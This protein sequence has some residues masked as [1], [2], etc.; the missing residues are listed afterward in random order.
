MLLHR[1]PLILR[2]AVRFL[3]AAFFWAAVAASR[4][5]ARE[6]RAPVWQKRWVRVPLNMLVDRNAAMARDIVERAAKAGYNGVVYADTKL[7]TW[8]GP[9]VGIGEKWKRNALAFRRLA[10]ER[11]MDFIVTAAPFGYAGGI[12]MHDPNLAAGY[13]VRNVSLRAAE[14][15]LVSICDVRIANPSF[16]EHRGDRFPSWFHDDPGRGSFAD[17]Q[18]VKD[19]SVSLRFEVGARTNKWGHNR[20][21]QTWVVRPFQQ[22]RVHYWI[23]LDKVTGNYQSLVLAADGKRTLQTCGFREKP[24]EDAP[25]RKKLRDTSADWCEQVVVFNSLNRRK[26]RFYIGIWGG[27]SG[28]MWVDGVRIE[29]V[30]TLNVLRRDD[31]PL[32]IAGKDGTVYIE[33]RDYRRVEDPKLGRARW[34]GTYGVIHASPGVLLAPDSRIREGQTVLFSAYHALPMPN[35]QMNCSLYN[36][37]VFEICR[38]S[39]KYN[40]E[41]FHPDGW[42]LAYDEMRTGGWE[43]EETKRFRNSGELL[44]YNV[45]RIAEIV[46]KNGGGKPMFVWSDM[47][48]P[49]HNARENYYLVNNTLAGSWEGLPKDMTVVTWI[50]KRKSLEFFSKRGHPQVVAG[51]YDRDVTEDF[52]H[53]LKAVRGVPNVIGTMYCTWGGN[54]DDIGRFADVWWG[55]RRR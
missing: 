11:G 9:A 36:P 33:G 7:T 3:G 48:D 49:N 22:Y 39:V 23:K 21:F 24:A 4:A 34:R 32:R 38:D 31:L 43:P 35:D 20:V 12:L 42:F 17:V 25:A 8:W 18:V 54:W 44:A 27:K 14:G 37:K 41:L 55:G 6:G 30:P 50:A 19:G 52:Q 13:P 29:A 45:R 28:R 2:N 47:F 5:S 53:W 46:R 1:V 16:E 15:R 40:R 26:V 51:Y 10:R